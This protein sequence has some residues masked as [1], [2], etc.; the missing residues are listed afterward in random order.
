[1]TIDRLK[2]EVENLRSKLSLSEEAQ[3]QDQKQQKSGSRF[4][5]ESLAS[6]PQMYSH[7]ATQQQIPILSAPTGRIPHQ[8]TQG[9]GILTS[10]AVEH[11]QMPLPQLPLPSSPT[12]Q[13]LMLRHPPSTPLERSPTP[14]IR[15]LN[16][17]S[18]S[19]QKR[20]P[21]SATS[22][23]PPQQVVGQMVAESLYPAEKE[24]L[25]N[26]SSSVLTALQERVNALQMQTRTFVQES[27][28]ALNTTQSNGT[29]SSQQLAE[30][31]NLINWYR[32]QSELQDERISRLFMQATTA[33]SP[34]GGNTTAESPFS[35]PRSTLAKHHLETGE[36]PMSS[37]LDMSSLSILSLP[38]AEYRI[39][40]ANGYG[41]RS[42]Y[43][44]NR[45]MSSLDP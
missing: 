25:Q 18:L 19:S 9:G 10:G 26:N 12:E 8:L 29:S 43:W 24:V 13:K 4:N 40:N 20:N 33:S 31:T 37:S 5:Q 32:T 23:S 42:G 44:K 39:T 41:Y 38:A 16:V 34:A 2:V 27:L 14:L 21:P 17:P 45:Y 11:A 6:G 15:N 35:S 36:S 22:V 30:N 3:A 1:M 28:Q 7:S